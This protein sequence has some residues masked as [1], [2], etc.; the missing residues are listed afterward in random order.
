MIQRD[1]DL[2]MPG[3]IVEK[4]EGFMNLT[5]SFLAATPPDENGDCEVHLRFRQNQE[6]Q[7]LTQGFITGRQEGLQQGRSEVFDRLR[8]YQS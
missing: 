4:F 7:W 2:I 1:I 3:E 8:H 5:L 6:Q